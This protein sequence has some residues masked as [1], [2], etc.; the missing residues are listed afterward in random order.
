MKAV[1]VQG[2][3]SV[4]AAAGQACS[5]RFR[6]LHL[7]SRTLNESC[8]PFEPVSCSGREVGTAQRCSGDT[9]PAERTGAGQP[10][11]AGAAQ[12]LIPCC[13]V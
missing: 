4:R 9:V 3:C 7:R 10:V 5:V 1:V 2:L 12:V 8:L 13:S 6:I 11:R